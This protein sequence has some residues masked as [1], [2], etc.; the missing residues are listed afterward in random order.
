M[1]SGEIPHQLKTAKVIPL[2]KSGDKCIMD[3]YRPIALLDSFS[4]ILE[5]V[6]CNRLTKFLEENNKITPYQFGFRKQH[7]PVHPMLHFMNFV[8]ENL[9][10]KQH[11]LAIFC[12]LRK[13]FDCCDHDIL[14]RKLNNLGIRG[15]EL[16]WFKNYLTNRQQFV[17]ISD[18]KVHLCPLFL[19][20]PK[21]PF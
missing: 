19:V 3:N 6:V 2:F 13:A 4:K 21:A 7:S 8:S 18:K 1:E 9:E 15:T 20:F 12:D 10:K 14:L 16:I 17:S 11:S 5:K